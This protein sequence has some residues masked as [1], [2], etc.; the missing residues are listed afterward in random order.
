MWQNAH[1]QLKNIIQTVGD[2]WK[3]VIANSLV[4]NNIHNS[5]KRVTH[6]YNVYT[7]T[8]RGFEKYPIKTLPC[9]GKNTP[10]QEF[11]EVSVPNVTA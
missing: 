7:C 2:V 5:S 4:I 10:K 8:T 6:V 11:R 1:Q 9:W 3:S